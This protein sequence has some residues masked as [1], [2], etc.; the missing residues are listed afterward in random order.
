[1]ETANSVCIRTLYLFKIRVSIT[2]Q[3]PAKL[4]LAENFMCVSH[5]S[6]ACYMTH[7][8]TLNVDTQTTWFNMK[9][10]TLLIT[11]FSPP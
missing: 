10:M 7:R 4:F 1:M 8:L 11:K 6:S 2:V 5:H 9:I 3:L